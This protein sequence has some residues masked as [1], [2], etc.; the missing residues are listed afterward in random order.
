MERKLIVFTDLDGTFLDHDTYSFDPVLETFLELKKRNIPVII[1]T[2]KTRTEVDVLRGPLSWNDPFIVEN[3]AAVFF[4]PGHA[5]GPVPDS[6]PIEG[7]QAKVF[8]KRYADVRSFLALHRQTFKITGFADMTIR[9][10]SEIT[11]LG[12]EEAARA[13]SREFTEPFLAEE[14]LEVFAELA[15]RKGLKI[16]RGGRFYHLMG[17]E[18]DKGRAVEWM[19]RRYVEWEPGSEMMSVGLGEGE[20]DLSFL[21]RVDLPVLVRRLDGSHVEGLEVPNCVKTEKIGPSGWAEAIGNL[22][23]RLS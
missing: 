8:G 5:P 23:T 22:L 3:G 18:Q 1:V 12:L 21:R 15:R 11:G 16:T 7:Y 2:S 10:V 6:V 13:M 4:P 20:N 14:S 17:A 9:R 19:I